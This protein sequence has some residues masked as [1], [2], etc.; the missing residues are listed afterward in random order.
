MNRKTA[1]EN[2]FILVFEKNLRKERDTRAAKIAIDDILQAE[3]SRDYFI[4]TFSMPEMTGFTSQSYFST[5]FK[6][7]TGMTPSQYKKQKASS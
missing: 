5:A 2:A 4:L 6:A 3:Y 7:Y 1:R